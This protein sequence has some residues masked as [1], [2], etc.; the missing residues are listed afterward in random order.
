[1]HCRVERRREDVELPCHGSRYDRF[2][3]VINGPAN[4]DLAP[5]D[6]GEEERANVRHG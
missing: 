6:E 4:R 2:R 1:L 5:A 3:R